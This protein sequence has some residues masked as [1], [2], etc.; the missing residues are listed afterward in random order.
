MQTVR[1]TKKPA[2][3]AY[4]IR[5]DHELCKA[6]DMEVQKEC[7]DMDMTFGLDNCSKATITKGRITHIQ[8][9][10]SGETEAEGLIVA[11]QD[12]NIIRVL[13][14]NS[15]SKCRVCKDKNEYI[16]H[17]TSGYQKLAKREY[18]EEHDTVC[19]YYI[20]DSAEKCRQ[21]GG[22]LCTEFA[23]MYLRLGEVP[24]K[25]LCSHRAVSTA[26][27]FQIHHHSDDRIED[28][29]KPSKSSGITPRR[30]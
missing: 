14:N 26:S 16:D 11:A 9:I 25:F 17:I 2:I 4:T 23:E 5:H 28:L 21:H 29:E 12:H 30:C 22:Y 1:C 6:L 7:S 24:L 3:R 8:N 18:I 13:R 15:D 27:F 19:K 10:Q 20:L